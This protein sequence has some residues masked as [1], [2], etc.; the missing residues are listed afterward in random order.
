MYNFNMYN[1]TGKNTTNSKIL[2]H[3]KN[4]HYTTQMYSHQQITLE[5]ICSSKNTIKSNCKENVKTIPA[6]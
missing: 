1:Y 3:G 6:K 5:Q 2:I 4:I